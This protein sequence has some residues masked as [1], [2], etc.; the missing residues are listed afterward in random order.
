MQDGT[1]FANGWGQPASRRI[2]WVLDNNPGTAPAPAGPSGEEGKSIWL[3][4]QVSDGVFSLLEE[5]YVVANP[6]SN[7]SDGD[8]FM[9]K[10]TSNG[11][12]G[13]DYWGMHDPRIVLAEP[14]TE[15]STWRDSANFQVI[16][17]YFASGEKVDIIE[18]S[19]G[20]IKLSVDISQYATALAPVAICQDIVLELDSNGEASISANDIDNGSYD[21]DG[22]PI[23]FS[24]DKSYFT[25]ADLGGNSV[26]LTVTDD[27]GNPGAC[28]AT[29]NVIDTIPPI[30]T[31]PSD[32]TIECDESSDPANTG[33]ATATDACDPSPTITYSDVTLPGSCPEESTITRTWT[34]T[35]ASG[36]SSSCSQIVE[37]VDTTPP[38]IECNAPLTVS[39]VD[40]PISFTAT[41]TD[42]CAAD[43]SVEIVGYDCFFFTK[44]GKKIDRTNS[45]IVQANEDT[46]T[47]EDSGGIDD[48]IT[49]N[50]RSTDNCG[51]VA[52][53][54]CSIIVQKF[55]P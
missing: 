17:P 45:C 16:V 22:D 39:P 34:A 12:A 26:V 8:T 49:W 20:N 32:T 9:I 54:T 38:E 46:F 52:E 47:I 15:R 28:T 3:N 55:Q 19:T 43:P 37:V 1:F 33:Y 42:S 27:Q 21:P 31:C 13:L 25:C 35:D 30:I 2:Q 6:P 5:S 50:V 53:S 29:V 44:K 36:N 10:V 4:M 24:L 51:N 23:T 40:T 11:N 14:G 48:N 18:T 7:R 41:A